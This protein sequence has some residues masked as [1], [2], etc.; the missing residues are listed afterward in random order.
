MRVHDG[1][2]RAAREHGQLVRRERRAAVARA[3]AA[4]RARELRRA[5][6]AGVAVERQARGALPAELARTRKPARA[7]PLAQRRVLEQP[8]ERRGDRALDRAGRTAAR[9]RRPPRAARRRSSRPPA[10]RAPS[11]RAPAGRSPRTARGTRTRARAPTDPRAPRPRPSREAH[12]ALDAELRARLAQLASRARSDS[13][14][15]RAAD[16]RSAESRASAP[17]SASRFLCGRFADR[18]ST[19]RRSPRSN[20]ARTSRS[21]SGA[22]APHAA[23]AER[24]DVDA[25][26]PRR[27]AAR[28]RS[29]RVLCE[30][31]I[32]RS[33]RRTAH[34]T[35][36]LMPLSRMP[37]CASGKR[38]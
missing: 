13:R 19:T 7:Q 9:R 32:T 25:L 38:A 28:I 16:G 6:R 2:H 30:S 24:H 20:R 8:A 35:S 26:G 10:R 4:D 23:E 31:A 18:L 21:G 36:T 29:S 12:V 22:C 14:G 15:A 37:A 17:I 1:G 34:G 3:L 11:P 27:R 33:E 5:E